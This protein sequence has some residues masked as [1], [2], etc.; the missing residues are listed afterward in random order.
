[1]HIFERMEMENKGLTFN[2]HATFDNHNNLAWLNVCMSCL[3]Q[4]APPAPL[5]QLINSHL[6]IVPHIGERNIT[7]VRRK[8]REREKER[9]RK[10]GRESWPWRTIFLKH[11]ADFRQ[12]KAL[13]HVSVCVEARGRTSVNSRQAQLPRAVVTRCRS[14]IF[15]RTTG[16]NAVSTPF[17]P[18]CR[19]L[20]SIKSESAAVPTARG[21]RVASRFLI[22]L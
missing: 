3:M 19:C 11:K 5:F 8:M 10:T 17:S 12:K 15:I 14:P 1:M 2:K 13:R 9:K 22:E 18:S 20:N 21:A 4:I 7:S 16:T 6:F